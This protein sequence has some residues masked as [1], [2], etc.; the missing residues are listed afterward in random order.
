MKPSVAPSHTPHALAPCT[1]AQKTPAEKE[2]CRV[3]KITLRDDGGNGTGTSAFTA[4]HLWGPGK[5][6]SRPTAAQAREVAEWV[7]PL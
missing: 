3:L 2:T 4:F 7:D 1:A 5:P 6:Q